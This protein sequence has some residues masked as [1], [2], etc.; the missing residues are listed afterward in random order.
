MNK[1]IEHKFLVKGDFKKD[2]KSFHRITQAYL[3]SVPERSVR[4]RRKDDKAFLTI[5]GKSNAAGTV[6]FEFEKEIS[7]VDAENL[8]KICEPGIIDKIRY[9]IPAGKHFWEIDEFLGK[10]KGLLI[11]E[12]ELQHE[13]E[14]FEKPDWLGKE[15]TGDKRYF[16]AY[17]SNNPYLS[18]NGAKKNTVNLIPETVS[19]MINYFGRDVR[20]INHA[21]KVYAYAQNIGKLEKLDSEKQQ[22]LEICS[23][24]HDI[25]I[26]ESERKHNSSAGKYQEIE[27]P[28]IAEKILAE[29]NLSETIVERIKFIIGNHHTYSKIDGLDF[30]ILVEADFLVNFEEANEPIKILLSVKKRIFKTK[31]GTQFLENIFLQ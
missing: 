11:A 8:F 30:Q 9:I 4:V 10:N 19:K 23:I 28:A 25:G 21:L 29:F 12:I 13:D 14:T 6:R 5:K 17:I 3:S 1:E 26:K 20:R 15:V 31:T 18:R 2:A 24:L 7:L 27:G 22:I 16:N